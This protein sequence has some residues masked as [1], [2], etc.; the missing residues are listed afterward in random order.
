MQTAREELLAQT[1]LMRLF[2]LV[3]SL[4]I[5]KVNLL[6]KN[7]N[8]PTNRFGTKIVLTS[9]KSILDRSI[10]NQTPDLN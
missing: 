3:S 1:T 4:Y 2:H 8:A 10:L 9:P 5:N 6:V 7:Q